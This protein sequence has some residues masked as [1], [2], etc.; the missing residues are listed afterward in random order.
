MMNTRVLIVQ[1]L[2][3]LLLTSAALCLIY[4]SPLSSE[5]NIFILAILS[6]PFTQLL[7]KWELWNL[8]PFKT[9][10]SVTSVVNGTYIEIIGIIV[11]KSTWWVIPF[12]WAF[13]SPT[14]SVANYFSVPVT[15]GW[16][17]HLIVSILLLTYLFLFIISLKSMHTSF[18]V[19]VKG[20]FKAFAVAGF[21][22]DVLIIGFLGGSLFR[23]LLLY[24]PVLASAVITAV[25]VDVAFS[26]SHFPNVIKY[27]QFYA[28]NMTGKSEMSLFRSFMQMTLVSIPS[29]LFLFLTGSVWYAIAM[30][31]LA[32][33]G[34]FLPRNQ[35]PVESSSEDTA[36]GL[37]TNKMDG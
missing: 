14:I 30:H 12:F 32:D 34:A 25:M 29:W 22:E 8:T 24:L 4:I 19:F 15:T 21:P 27:R 23:L 36:S 31:T 16:I 33:L 35:L 20:L 6:W 7:R 3:V 1:T 17:P 5:I 13:L 2:T 11:R 10:I 18:Y 37:K 9:N 28:E 26:I